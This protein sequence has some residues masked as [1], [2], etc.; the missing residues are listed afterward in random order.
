MLDVLNP[1]FYC[2]TIQTM[3]TR[4]ML[5]RR[6]FFILRR[7]RAARA[8]VLQFLKDFCAGV[9]TYSM[10][11]AGEQASLRSRVAA[12]CIHTFYII[13]CDRDLITGKRVVMR[14]KNLQ[15]A[16]RRFLKVQRS[17]IELLQ[18]CIGMALCEE[19]M[20]QHNSPS[21]FLLLSRLA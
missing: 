20:Q 14:I 6:G 21:K 1:L 11:A 13:L 15:R 18:V 9:S 19:A 12:R 17:R 2:F 16:T 7:K 8:G 10:R 4:F 3:I 5:M